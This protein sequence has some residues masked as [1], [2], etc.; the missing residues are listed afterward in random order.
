MICKIS[1]ADDTLINTNS[2]KIKPVQNSKYSTKYDAL[3]K[4]NVKHY[5]G[6]SNDKWLWIKS[7]AICESCLDENAHSECNARGVLQVMPATF[8]EI[9]KK[10]PD[11]LGNID[12]AKWNIQAGIYYDS[13][14]YNTWKN[15][16][17]ENDKLAYMFASYNGGIGNVLKAQ[18]I[19]NCNTW[20]E[21]K[22][23]A[24]QVKT[25]IYKQSLDYVDKIFALMGSIT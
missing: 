21:L 14:L 8:R 20:N 10:N 16:A 18:K 22:P 17:T 19:C 3:F 25:W 23:A 12:T 7:Q 11:I 13:T 4:A 2:I 24:K 5:F 15:E 9:K 1:Y 6:V